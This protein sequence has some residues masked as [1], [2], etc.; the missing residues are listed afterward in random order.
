MLIKHLSRPCYTSDA[1]LRVK[2]IEMKKDTEREGRDVYKGGMVLQEPLED[3][4]G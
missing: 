1:E 2:N 4:C 3:A